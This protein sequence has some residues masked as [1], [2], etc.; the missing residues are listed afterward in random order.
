MAS[1]AERTA[2]VTAV[3][4]GQGGH[5]HASLPPSSSYRG[6][7]QMFGYRAEAAAVGSM[8]RSAEAQRGL[9][10][11]TKHRGHRAQDSKGH[12]RVPLRRA[13]A[14]GGAFCGRARQ[15]LSFSGG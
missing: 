11:E 10:D 12:R 6:A 5:S 15:I 7:R 9:P 2:L 14:A 1:R 13:A 4:G 8:E 3:V